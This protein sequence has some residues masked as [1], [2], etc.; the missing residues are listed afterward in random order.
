[1]TATKAAATTRRRTQEERRREAEGRLLDAAIALIAQRG[2]LQT[3]LGD[4][5]EAAGYSRGLPSHHFKAKAGLI[6]AVRAEILRRMAALLT[7]PAGVNG[8]DALSAVTRAVIGAAQEPLA[9]AFLEFQKAAM[10]LDSP[11]RPALTAFAREAAA[12]LEVHI[13]A[14]QATGGIR[15]EIDPHAQAQLL[16]ASLRG[17]LAQQ[18][19]SAAPPPAEAAIAT[20]DQRTRRTLSA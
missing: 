6:E 14:G 17:V 10:P 13:R 11:H 9:S 12:K 15:A 1:M 7:P 19:L 2:I 3:S 5:G 18:L 4:V 20:L 16:L 8:L